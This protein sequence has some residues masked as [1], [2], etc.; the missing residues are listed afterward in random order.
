MSVSFHD[1]LEELLSGDHVV[2]AAA[3]VDLHRHP[4]YLAFTVADRAAPCLDNG[5]P[6]IL[7]LDQLA[8][9]LRATETGPLI[10]A[11]GGC[12]HDTSNVDWYDPD[13]DA[14]YGPGMAAVSR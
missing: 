11:R 6:L 12:L 2:R 7:T 10:K 3:F 9:H 5:K 4:E 1:L 8:A 13:A 14:G